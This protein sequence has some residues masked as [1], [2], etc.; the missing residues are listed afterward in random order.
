MKVVWRYINWWV[1]DKVQEAVELTQ[2]LLLVDASK[3][4]PQ[5]YQYLRRWYDNVAGYLTHLEEIESDPRFIPAYFLNTLQDYRSA[6][7]DQLATLRRLFDQFD[8]GPD[9]VSGFTTVQENDLWSNR[10]KAYD[11]LA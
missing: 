9:V 5:Q 10:S 11:Y 2:N 6:S 1:K 7:Q 3:I 4:E 8:A